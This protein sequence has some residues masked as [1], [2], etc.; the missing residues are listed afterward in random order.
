MAS[1]AA[2]SN[3]TLTLGAWDS[4]TVE[5]PPG[6]SCVV[7]S[8]VG[9]RIAVV[10]SGSRSFGPYASGTQVK[11]S[12]EGMAIQYQ[13][14]DGQEIPYLDDGEQRTL[15]ALVS[16]AG[17][18]GWPAQTTVTRADPLRQLLPV[19]RA[20]EWTVVNAANTTT[21]E[22]PADAPNAIGPYALRLDGEAVA[23]QNTSATK[24]CK[25]NL[26]TV[27]G[28]WLLL[29]NR[30]RHL[31]GLGWTVY[32]GQA[33]ALAPGN[34]WQLSGITNTQHVSRTPVW[35]AKS[36]FT[37]LD[38]TPSWANDMLAFR[39]RLDGAA[40]AR[41]TTDFEGLFTSRA[42]PAVMVSFDDGWDSSYS[43]GH[44][45]ARRRGIPLAHFLIPGLLGS[46]GYI[47]LAQAQEMRAQG[48][49][50]GLHGLDRWDTDTRRI[51]TDAAGL[52]ALGIDTQHA[53]YPEGQV[54]DDQAWQATRAAMVAAGVRTARMT[55]AGS[56]PFSTPVLRGVND[57]LFLPAYP[58]NSW[59]TL[60]Q[61]QA[62]VD[63]AEASGGTVI[64]YAHK[65]GG[66]AD[67]LTWVT[68]DYI[69]LMDY[70]QQRRLV[71]AIDTPRWDRW[72]SGAA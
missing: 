66:T 1:L 12:A 29:N 53:A 57:P 67:S 44:M 42:R 33:A 25:L 52:Q 71:G 7:E 38:G 19:G 15:Q 70:I 4:V 39:V 36:R 62:A 30:R 54:G 46:G 41:R 13:S 24:D 69:A 20:S 32:F 18:V 14:Q 61:A 55:A 60:A 28:V 63:E 2:G 10:N 8:P 65:L 59:I 27:A 35:L 51:A 37:V 31:T 40:S 9:T 50:L 45:E 3:T 48:D 34:R 22:V 47:T 21:A 49:Y 6:A 16:D 68:S 56:A 23:G 58:L 11:L 64:F 43:V 17:N 26:N 5:V 72:A